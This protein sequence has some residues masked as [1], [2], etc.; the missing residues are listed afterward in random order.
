MPVDPQN[1]AWTDCTTYDTQYEIVRSASD[2]RITVTA[3]DTEIP[4]GTA[5]ISVTR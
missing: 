5:V 4:P 2:N 1:G 3:P